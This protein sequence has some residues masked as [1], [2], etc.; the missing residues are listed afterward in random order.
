[1]LARALCIADDDP[2]SSGNANWVL[3][4]LGNDTKDEGW[5]GTTRGSVGSKSL[6]VP[7][8]SRTA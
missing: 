1:M 3:N 5:V 7:A 6:N 4:M 2:I 8:R